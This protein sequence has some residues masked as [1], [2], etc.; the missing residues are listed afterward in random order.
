MTLIASAVRCVLAE[1]VSR[2]YGRAVT[3]PQWEYDPRESRHWEW[4]VGSANAVWTTNPRLVLKAKRKY[5]L[6][7]RPRYESIPVWVAQVFDAHC[8]TA[9]GA[10]WDRVGAIH[11]L[12]ARSL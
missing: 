1:H 6:K 8:A 2:S 4:E 10:S 5:N 12:P 9:V 7:W 11:D 3:S